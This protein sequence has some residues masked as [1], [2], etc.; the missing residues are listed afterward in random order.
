VDPIGGE[1]AVEREYEL[2]LELRASTVF[3]E[4]E[5]HRERPVGALRDDLV[6]ARAPMLVITAYSSV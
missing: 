2:F 6:P 3:L 5:F 1:C 4:G